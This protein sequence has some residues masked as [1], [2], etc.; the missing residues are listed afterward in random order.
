MAKQVDP[1][2]LRMAPVV[3][4]EAIEVAQKSFQY[5]GRVPASM[6]IAAFQAACLTMEECFTEKEIAKWTPFIP[7]LQ[8][9][10]QQAMDEIHE[11][12]TKLNKIRAE[13]EN[14]GK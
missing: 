11:M 9:L 7:D 8:R 10:C 5:P 12:S 13:H 4:A 14:A 2:I 1:E 3:M 6:K